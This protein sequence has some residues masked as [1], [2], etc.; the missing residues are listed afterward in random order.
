MYL[1][2]PVSSGKRM[3]PEG[4][5]VLSC[6]PDVGCN[7]LDVP[8]QN[9]VVRIQFERAECQNRLFGEEMQAEAFALLVDACPQEDAGLALPVRI[10]QFG[11]GERIPYL[12]L[13][14]CGKRLLLP[15]LR[16]DDTGVIEQAQ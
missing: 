11:V 8:V 15:V 13:Q 1:L 14:T 16:L 7:I 4:S 12:S 10:A 6:Q 2:H 3:D 5:I 9:I